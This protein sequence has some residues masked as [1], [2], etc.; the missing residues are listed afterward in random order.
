[1]PSRRHTL[2]MIACIA[3]TVPAFA[4]DTSF[5]GTY[6][7]QRVLTKGEPGACVAK[8]PVSITVQGDK[9]TFT[10]SAAKGY[11]IGFSPQADGA[12]GELVA[13]I[14]GKAVAIDGRV[15]AGVLDA[16]VTSAN[17]THHWHLEKQH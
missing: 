14:G 2:P 13:D 8:D 3:L 1:M 12:F 6:I 7:G 15:G 17:C 10:D 4:A 11:A 16:D 9:L 5:D